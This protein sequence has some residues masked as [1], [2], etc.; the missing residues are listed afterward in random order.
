MSNVRVSY[1]A[2]ATTATD[3]TTGSILKDTR[4]RGVYATGIGVFALVGTSTDP[5]GQVTGNKV[6]FANTTANDATEQFFND[7][8]GI[9]MSG[10]VKVSALPSGGTMTIYYG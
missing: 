9:R 4:I 7:N 5:F 10:T 3:L 1:M 6:K 2:T 8:L